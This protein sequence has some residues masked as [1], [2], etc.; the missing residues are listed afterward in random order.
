MSLSVIRNIAYN[1]LMTTQVQISVASANI[2][3]ADTA[4]YTQKTANQ[5]SLVYGGTNAGT[6]VT[7]ISSSVDKY[8]LKALISATSNLGAAATTDSYADRLQQLFGSVSGDDETG[9]SIANSLASL[10][11][12][13]LELAQTPESET[14]QTQVVSSLDSLATQLRETSAGIQNLR[15]DADGSIGDAVADANELLHT[16]DDLNEQIVQAKNTGQS[17]ADL[18]DKRNSAL[19]ELSGLMDVTSFVNNNGQ[20]QVYTTSGQTLLDSNVHE[21]SYNPAATVSSSTVFQA[22]TVDG[23]DITSQIKSGTIGALIEQRDEVL[24]DAQAELDQLATSLADA[25]NAVHNEGTAL[26]PP[27]QL[28]GSAEV[29]ATDAFSGTGTVRFATVDDDGNLAA[30]QDLELSD[31]A[32]VGDLVAAIDGIDG[33]AA[34]I[35]SDGHVVISADNAGEGVAVNGLT[36]EVGSSQEGLSQWLGLNDMVSA[37]GASDFKIVASLLADPSGLAISLLSDSAIL[38]AGENVVSTGSTTITDQLAALFSDAVD[39]APAGSLGSSRTTFA[40]YAANIISG[41]ATAADNAAGAYNL[42]TSNQ[43][44]IEVSISSQSGVN[45]DEETARLSELENM[46]SSAAQILSIVNAMFESLLEAVQ[47]A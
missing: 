30:Y 8:L 46:Y 2:A 6:A 18:E 19:V 20:L 12:A 1:S 32:T 40:G 28:I 39:F 25:L 16:L 17:T 31:Y 27:S 34:S 35:D 10:E 15:A 7:G 44:T 45:I 24:P 14:L 21:L 38:T 37:T 23:N 42:A 36:G 3:N 47:S 4:G 9:T 26:P 13:L 29:S 11:S 5:T 43:S 41:V 33:L 22:I